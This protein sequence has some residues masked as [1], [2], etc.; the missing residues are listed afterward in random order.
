MTLLPPKR[1]ERRTYKTGVNKM[2][3]V[4]AE[5]DLMNGGDM[6]LYRQKKIKEKDILSTLRLRH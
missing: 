2:G 1:V 5:I 4:Y 3:L 6:Y